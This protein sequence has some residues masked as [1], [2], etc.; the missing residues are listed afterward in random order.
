LCCIAADI[1]VIFTFKGK[2][3]IT[4][5]TDWIKTHTLLIFGVSIFSLAMLAFSVFLLPVL[6]VNLPVDYFKKGR[7]RVRPV[8]MHPAVYVFFLF[9]KNILGVVLVLL[10][11]IMLA[12][13]GQGVITLLLGLMI[14]D[15]PGERRFLK[16]ILR[17]TR[18]FKAMNWLRRKKNKPPFELPGAD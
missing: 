5:I 7:P 8:W 10:G 17:K 1:M 3:M 18:A 6:I 16:Y 12:L 9:V 2:K 11:F 15:F 13:P 14:I 4:W